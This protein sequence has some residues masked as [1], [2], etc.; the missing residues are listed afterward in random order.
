MG[1][2]S[3]ETHSMIRLCK[4]PDDNAARPCSCLEAENRLEKQQLRTI[5]NLS[6][7]EEVSSSRDS[8]HEKLAETDTDLVPQN[9][10]DCVIILS[11]AS[12]RRGIGSFGAYWQ[13]RACI[14]GCGLFI[15]ASNLQNVLDVASDG[16]RGMLTLAQHVQG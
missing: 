8:D 1:L 4:V 14:C 13:A 16:S 3:G 12:S 7:C 15:A 6:S 5:C 11:P 9:Q 2:T 10:V